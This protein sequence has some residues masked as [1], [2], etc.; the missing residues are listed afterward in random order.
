[1]KHKLKI[2]KYKLRNVNYRY[3][4]YYYIILDIIREKGLNQKIRGLWY[5]K[6]NIVMYIQYLR[7]LKLSKELEQ[8]RD[9]VKAKLS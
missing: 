9:E 2:I 6:Y 5:S 8:L 7:Y 1:M 3:N 4:P